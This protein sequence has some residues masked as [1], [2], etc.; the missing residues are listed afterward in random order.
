M[1]N[2]NGSGNG[3][4]LTQ[5]LDTVEKTGNDRV[6]VGFNRRFAPLFT[7]LRDRFGPSRGPPARNTGLMGLT[8][9]FRR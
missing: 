3:H 9:V 2:G 5:V 8:P 6:M 1:A 4:K 7:E